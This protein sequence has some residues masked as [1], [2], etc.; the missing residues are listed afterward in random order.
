MSRSVGQAAGFSSRPEGRLPQGGL[1]HAA[2]LD[3][4]QDRLLDG[5]HFFG[6]AELARPFSAFD[7]SLRTIRA[8]EASQVVFVNDG[9][10][11]HGHGDQHG[12]HKPKPNVD[13]QQI[14]TCRGLGDGRMVRGAWRSC[15][16]RVSGKS[17]RRGRFQSP[18]LRQHRVEVP[19]TTNVDRRLESPPLALNGLSGRLV[20]EAK[21]V[22]TAVER[23]PYNA[24][25]IAT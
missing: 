21:P 20:G 18:K 9:V 17:D 15:S 22:P 11:P 5:F 13:T 14:R 2:A 23:R 4:L 7:A 1:Q 10:N 16:I 19:A 25:L 6:I 3:H 24:E 12:R 8:C